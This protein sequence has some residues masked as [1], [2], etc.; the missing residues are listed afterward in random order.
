MARAGAQTGHK[1]EGAEAAIP[2]AA[3]PTTRDRGTT[4]GEPLA[5]QDVGPEETDLDAL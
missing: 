2:S 3:G 1:A 5:P 4:V